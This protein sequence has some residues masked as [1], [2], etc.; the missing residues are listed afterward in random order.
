[1]K[2]VLGK[3]QVQSQNILECTRGEATLDNL[4]KVLLCLQD[5]TISR[6]IIR[7]PNSTDLLEETHD[8]E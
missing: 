6:E 4:C 7:G 8:D 1:M 5:I 2:P 3:D